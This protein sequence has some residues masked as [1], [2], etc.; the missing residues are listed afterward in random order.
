MNF[1]IIKSYTSYLNPEYLVIFLALLIIFAIALVM[2]FKS[3]KQIWYKHG[4]SIITTIGIFFTFMGITFGLVRF[5]PDNQ[6]SLHQLIGGLKLAFIPSTV[7]VLI[8]IVFK[9]KSSAHASNSPLKEL[10]DKLALNAATVDKL[11]VALG[12]LDWQV[13]YRKSLEQNI[14]HTTRLETILAAN[15]T[16]LTESLAN[17]K[18]EFDSNHSSLEEVIINCRETLTKVSNDLHI[19]TERL[20]SR[21]KGLF[22]IATHQNSFAESLQDIYQRFDNCIQSLNRFENLEQNMVQNLRGVLKQELQHLEQSIT[23]R[24]ASQL[25]D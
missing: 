5:D 18:Q 20:N 24:L 13:E 11:I 14:E 19:T 12:N 1:A 6:N 8:S 9:W 7:A 4:A 10:N 17:R 3:E 21:F 2:L 22:E 15:L 16:Q 23:D 25:Q